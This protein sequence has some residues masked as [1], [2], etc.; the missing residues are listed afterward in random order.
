MLFIIMVCLTVELA[1]RSHYASLLDEPPLPTHW[2]LMIILWV[3]GIT[4]L[5]FKIN[6]AQV[7][8]I[9]LLERLDVL[10]PVWNTESQMT[11]STIS[12][13]CCKYD[14]TFFHCSYGHIQI[15]HYKHTLNECRRV[16][17]KIGLISTVPTKPH[18]T[19]GPDDCFMQTRF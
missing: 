7:G 11:K 1:Y 9:S 4:Y 18:F 15:Y 8:P 10:F 19:L 5:P 6:R 12:I 17:G 13:C 2:V 16:W 14:I 3:F